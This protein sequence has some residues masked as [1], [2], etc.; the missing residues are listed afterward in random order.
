MHQDTTVYMCMYLTL[1]VT[2]R[3]DTMHIG[4]HRNAQNQSYTYADVIVTHSMPKG[5][6]TRT[7]YMFV[8]RNKRQDIYVNIYCTMHTLKSI[9]LLVSWSYTPQN[10]MLQ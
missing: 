7:E 1:A 2:L 3:Y 10:S 4:T 8:A 9:Y 6:F 5:T